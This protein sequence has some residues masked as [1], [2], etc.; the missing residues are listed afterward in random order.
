MECPN[1]GCI[2]HARTTW[3]QQILTQLIFDGKEGINVA[4]ISPW[5]DLRYVNRKLT[6]DMLTAQSHR[7]VIKTHL[8]VDAL[9]FSPR[10]K[11][12]YVARDGRDTLMSMHNHHMQANDE[13]YRALNDTPG[14]VGPKMPR[15]NP[16][17]PAYFDDWLANDGY[18]W[19]PFWENIRS[20][21]NVRHLPNVLLIHYA[22][23]KADMRGQIR[24]LADYIGIEITAQ[25]RWDD[26][27]HHCTFEYMR[28]HAEL[29]VPRGGKIFVEGPKAFLH[30]GRNGSWKGVLSAEQTR[31]YQERAVAELGAECATW[32][33]TGG[34][35][36]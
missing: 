25:T 27:V 11:Y 34:P 20:W 18:P 22:D 26:I 6:H 12:V 8:P 24:R 1:W 16:D 14:L 28:E 9:V 33:E 31:A 15:P 23:L 21:W 19:W 7:R 4:T 35:L 10:A 32:L 5:L 30:R 3:V 29:T 13:W 36:P 2:L 17:V